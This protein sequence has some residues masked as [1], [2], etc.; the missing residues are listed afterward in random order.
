M[1][2]SSSSYGQNIEWWR[3]QWGTAERWWRAFAD[4]WV[5]IGRPFSKCVYCGGFKLGYFPGEKFEPRA[6]CDR[7]R[8]VA[9]IIYSFPTLRREAP[10]LTPWD[11]EKWARWWKTSGAL[12][13]GSR[14]AVAFC[15]SL[16]A[17][18][19]ADHWKRRGWSFDVVAAFGSWDERHRAAFLKWCANPWRP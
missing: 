17:G 8:F 6:H 3:I 13:A 14:H 4:A 7:E 16:W 1:M 11:P 19:N 18:C 9:G 12:T 5:N 10:G 15:L 2:L